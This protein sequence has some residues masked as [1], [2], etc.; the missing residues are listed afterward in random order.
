MDN[1]NH[2]ENTL[3]SDLRTPE[4]KFISVEP[5]TTIGQA[6]QVYNSTFSVN[7][8]KILNTHGI[9]MI[10]VLDPLLNK[11]YGTVNALDICGFIA[12]DSGSEF[13]K[14]TLEYPLTKVLRK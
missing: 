2:L 13:K 14:E 1:N 8:C 5:T 9:R 12:G 6:L 11:F 10:P 7:Y 4:R 3:L